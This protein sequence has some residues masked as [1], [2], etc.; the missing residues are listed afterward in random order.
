MGSQTGSL[1]CRTLNAPSYVI[2]IVMT[3]LF[4]LQQRVKRWRLASWWLDHY[5]PNAL[6]HD[7]GWQTCTLVAAKCTGVQAHWSLHNQTKTTSTMMSKMITEG[8]TSGQLTGGGELPICVNLVFN[9]T[10]NKES[11]LDCY[12]LLCILC[13][14]V[15]IFDWNCLTKPSQA[16]LFLLLWVA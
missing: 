13:I 16:D 8:N 2:I 1:S 15:E 5:V 10:L 9:L 6:D 12:H 11:V 7:L 14:K 4:I 3:N